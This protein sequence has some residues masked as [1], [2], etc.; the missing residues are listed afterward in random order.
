MTKKG[1]TSP[2]P[3][4]KQTAIK[5]P[6]KIDT[7]EQ[8]A[9]DSLRLEYYKVLIDYMKYL[10][11]LCTTLIALFIGLIQLS[12]NSPTTEITPV[13]GLAP[14]ALIISIIMSTIVQIP[15]LSLS[16][17]TTE[18]IESKSQGNDILNLMVISLG[19]FLLGISGLVI[20]VIQP[21]VIE[22]FS[23]SLEQGYKLLYALIFLAF[24]GYLF[25]Q[26]LLPSKD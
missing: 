14:F 15:I 24:I 17:A 25:K 1:N 10:T 18:E 4:N 5:P 13:S 20:S 2:K 11:T 21:Y 8:Q 12:P 26:R 3:S 23:L 19:G 6:E 9:I 7:E 22:S 16:R